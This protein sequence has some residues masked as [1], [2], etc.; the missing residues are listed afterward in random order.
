MKK[1][2]RLHEIDFLSYLHLSKQKQKRLLG[3]KIKTLETKNSELKKIYSL[4]FFK[5]IIINPN[6]CLHFFTNGRSMLVN[7][8]LWF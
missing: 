8:F 7:T 3:P 6:F 5:N 4:H 2:N 1:K